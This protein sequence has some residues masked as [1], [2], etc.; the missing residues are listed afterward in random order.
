MGLNSKMV[1]DIIIL[2]QFHCTSTLIPVSISY[3]CSFGKN[4]DLSEEEILQY[5]NMVGQLN[6]F[7]TGARPEVAYDMCDFSGHGKKEENAL[8][9]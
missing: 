2:D 7:A 8:N 5:H 3:Q 4:C 1:T 9:L 6:L